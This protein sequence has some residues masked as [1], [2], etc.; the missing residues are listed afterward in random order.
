[1]T[2]RV[3]VIQLKARDGAERSSPSRRKGRGSRK[4]KQRLRGGKPRVT[5]SHQPP[6]SERGYSTRKLKRKVRTLAWV[7]SR[8]QDMIDNRIRPVYKELSSVEVA[9]GQ[10]WYSG[11]RENF[12][13]SRRRPY[14]GLLRV[15][16]KVLGP[17]ISSEFVSFRNLLEAFAPV[18]VPSWAAAG[19]NPFQ[20]E[21]D[22][23]VRVEHVPPPPEAESSR[24]VSRRRNRLPLPLCR[25]CGDCHERGAC[26]PAGSRLRVVHLGP[27]SKSQPH[28]SRGRGGPR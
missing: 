11:D 10:R 16:R 2:L 23:T 27:L 20:E 12:Y 7:S 28:G 14:D 15:G 26:P 21:G 4:G 1:L 24:Q 17:A 25:H 22:P 13:L 8:A 5:R 6:I 18:E 3:D 19:F 9:R